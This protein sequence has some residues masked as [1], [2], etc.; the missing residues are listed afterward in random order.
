MKMLETGRWR[1]V[2]NTYDSGRKYWELYFIT[3]EWGERCYTFIHNTETL[4]EALDY[5]RRNK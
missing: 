3:H 4:A 5:C 1:L 2:K